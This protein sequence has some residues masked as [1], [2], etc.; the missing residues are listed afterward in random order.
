[1]GN[2]QSAIMTKLPLY[3]I[4]DYGCEPDQL[5]SREDYFHD[6]ICSYLYFTIEAPYKH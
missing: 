3:V 5:L 2:L 4:W 6:E 1:M